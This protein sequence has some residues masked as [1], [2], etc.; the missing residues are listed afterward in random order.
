M[1]REAGYYICSACGHSFAR[2]VRDR[3]AFAHAFGTAW[4]T[5]AV[6]P[7]C[8]RGD[9]V[10]A[11]PCGNPDCP[12]WRTGAERLCRDCRRALRRAL[13]AAVAPWSTA[14]LEQV[15]IWLEGSCLTALLE[16]GADQ[17]A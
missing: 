3:R 16:K 9:F 17:E 11:Y 15:E 10:P 6:C 5:A 13:A 4:D 12:G 14:E 1:N 2:P 8:G 7:R